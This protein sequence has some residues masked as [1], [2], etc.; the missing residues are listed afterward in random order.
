MKMMFS[1][2]LLLLVIA[3]PANS[4]NFFEVP[5]SVTKSFQEKYPSAEDVSWEESDGLFIAT[6]LEEDFYKEA[7]FD[8][9]GSWIET[10]TEITQDDLPDAINAYISSKYEDVEYYDYILLYENPHKIQYH[11]D[12]EIDTEM[13]SL[14]FNENGQVVRMTTV[15][16]VQGA[17]N[18]LR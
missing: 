4:G 12:F 17:G 10:T 11:V 7:T 13:I 16:R 14:V 3:V 6:F 15:K 5:E 18:W 8:Q 9:K 2:I 1:G